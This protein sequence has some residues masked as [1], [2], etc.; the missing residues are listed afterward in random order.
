VL[1][2]PSSGHH[3]EVFAEFPNDATSKT[4]EGLLRVPPG[5]LRGP[6]TVGNPILRSAMRPHSG[7]LNMVPHNTDQ[8]FTKM[9]PQE[10]PLVI[11]ITERE[12]PNYRINIV[13]GGGF[14][15]VELE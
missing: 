6:I 11:R 8:P 2:L 3:G 10:G 5:R 4:A 9:L 15:C 1:H 13:L 14:F 12:K 7:T